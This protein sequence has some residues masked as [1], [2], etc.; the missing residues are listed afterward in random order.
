M[1]R[2][3]FSSFRRQTYRKMLGK[4]YEKEDKI[5]DLDDVLKYAD[6]NDDGIIDFDEW[7]QDLIK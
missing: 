5:R 6:V 7:R 3:G 1:K 2:L 4:I